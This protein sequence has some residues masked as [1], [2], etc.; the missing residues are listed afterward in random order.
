MTR[1]RLRL[2]LL[3]FLLTACFARCLADRAE[4]GAGQDLV[5]GSVASVDEEF[6]VPPEDP[7]Y[8]PQPQQRGTRPGQGDGLVFK[9]RI[10]PHWFHQNSRF[11]YRND[12]PGGTREFVV[13][14]AERGTRDL[15]FDH[16]KLA[17][18][19]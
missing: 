6:A 12:L 5:A 16:R 7:W 2:F 19:L 8:S 11:W 14:D 10:A 17:A 18:S 13:V 9:L 4:A 3:G 1:S 15:A